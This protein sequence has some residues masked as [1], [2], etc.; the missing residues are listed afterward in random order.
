MA[1]IRATDWGLSGFEAGDREIDRLSI[2]EGHGDPK[3]VAAIG[4]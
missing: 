2:F 1:P 3:L 4:P